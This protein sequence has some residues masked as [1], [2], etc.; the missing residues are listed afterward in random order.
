MLASLVGHFLGVIIRSQLFP[1]NNY[2][3]PGILIAVFSGAIL[4]F[5]IK[6]DLKSYD[7]DYT[8]AWKVSGIVIDLVL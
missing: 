5:A 6:S 3:V 1:N 7:T 8:P 2:L 4:A